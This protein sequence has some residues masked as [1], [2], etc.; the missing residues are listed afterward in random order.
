[1]GWKGKKMHDMVRK[2]KAWHGMVRK[3]K[4][5]VIARFSS[6][7]AKFLRMHFSILLC[8]LEVPF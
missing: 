2:G 5:C 8:R 4:A 6:P 7:Y 1:M 3:R